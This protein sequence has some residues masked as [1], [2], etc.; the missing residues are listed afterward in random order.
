MDRERSQQRLMGTTIRRG[1]I[2]AAWVFGLALV[3]WTRPAAAYPQFQFSTGTTRCGQCHYSP[4][5]GGLITQWG[6]D[7]SADTISLGG[8]GGFLHGAWTPPSWLALGL[9]FRYAGI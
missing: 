3:A 2:V 5:G 9:D 8:N 7:E 1:S 4:S 6:R